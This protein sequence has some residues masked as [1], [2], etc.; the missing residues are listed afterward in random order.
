M[1]FGSRPPCPH[2]GTRGCRRPIR[3]DHFYCYPCWSD[4]IQRLADRVDRIAVGASEI[5]IGRTCDPRSRREEHIEDCGRGGLTVIHASDDIYEVCAIE[6]ALLREFEGHP[7]L[8]NATDRSLGG[9]SPNRR[10]YV[11]VSWH[12]WGHGQRG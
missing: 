5:Y 8:T 7:K 9:G 1:P 12:R 3:H 11:Y 6:E 2:A 10:N 4:L